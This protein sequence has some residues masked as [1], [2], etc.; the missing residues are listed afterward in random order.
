MDWSFLGPIA[1]SLSLLAR[2]EVLALVLLGNVIG[3][4]FGFIPGLSGGMAFVILLPLTFGWDPEVALWFLVGMLGTSSFGGAMPAILINV[5]GTTMNAATTFDGY[6]MAQRGEATRALGIAAMASIQGAVL[7]LLVLLALI[8]LMR[9]IVLAFGPPE[10]FWLVVMGLATI[11]LAAHGSFVKGLASGGVGVLLSLV[12]FSSV[13]GVARFSG[14]SDYFWD[15]IQLVSLFIGLF[16][17][18]QA[19]EFCVGGSSV[20][21]PGAVFAGWSGLWTGFR[22]VLRAPGITIRSSIV[23]T[24]IGIIPGIGGTAAAFISYVVA[25]Q[26]SRKRHLFHRGNPEGIIASEAA[27]NAK[28]FGALVPMLALGIPGSVEAGLVLGALIFFGIQPGPFLMRDHP[29]AVWA[30]ILSL[31]VSNVFGTF[32]GIAF[33]NGLARL[34]SIRVVYLAPVI[35]A[36][37]MVGTYLWRTNLW[38][39]FVAIAAGLIGYVMNKAG[40]SVVTLIIG[41]LLGNLAER[42]FAQSMMISN[43]SPLIF[44]QGPV[45]ITIAVLTILFVAAVFWRTRQLRAARPRLTRPA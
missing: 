34:T 40:F 13:L 11:A 36:A 16:A 41:Y 21:R 20:A 25:Q 4:T 45:T 42:A 37:S 26:F 30:L 17:V 29:G 3:L 32:L 2:P 18:A 15:G 33:A 9:A 24:I 12:G 19:I 31:A 28:E 8:P 39:M 10:V 43:G 35:L 1:H 44:F 7:G 38:D 22:D 27:S 14:R 5:P 6:P 23:G